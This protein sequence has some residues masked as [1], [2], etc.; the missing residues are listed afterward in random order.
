MRHDP[1]APLYPALE[2]VRAVSRRVALAVAEAAAA[3]GVAPALPPAEL[4][5]RVDAEMWQP[6]YRP[7]RREQQ[8]R[9]EGLA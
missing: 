1:L 7:Y 8:E 9:G 2:D 5:R 6:V 3:E 4:E